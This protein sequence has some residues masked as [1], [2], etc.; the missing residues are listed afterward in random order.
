MFQMFGR[1]DFRIA[2]E[3][4]YERFLGPVSSVAHS[5]SVDLLPLH[6]DVYQFAP[7]GARPCWTLVTGGMSDFRQPTLE[8][9]PPGIAPRAEL[10]MYVRE[11]QGWM[12][13]L[14]K[15]LAEMP[16]QRATCLHWGHTVPNGEPIID[17][18]E[19]TS[20]IFVPPSCETE[21]F[22][23]FSVDGDHVAF[24]MV[25]PI[26]EA[27]RAYAIE[28]GSAALGK[29]MEDSKFNF[30]IDDKRKPLV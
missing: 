29:L 21:E 1:D 27:E 11:P 23:D 24:L 6:I 19:F 3:T 10:L 12:P 4:H 22:E 2:R 26:T 30:I 8:E 7:G 20:F 14:L 25:V 5:M 18:S 9:A 16:F 17:D 28:H 13:S 15:G